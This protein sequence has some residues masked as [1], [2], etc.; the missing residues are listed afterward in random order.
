MNKATVLGCMSAPYGIQEVQV[1]CSIRNGFPGFDI[2]GLPGASVKESRE[3]V[4][5]AMRSSGVGFPQ[6]R[7]LLNLS[8][9]SIQKEGTSL[10]LPIA[11]SI[12]LC[13]ATQSCDGS[14]TGDIRIMAVGELSL[15]GTLIPT[16]ECSGATAKAASTMCQLCLVPE[17][18]IPSPI[19]GVV[20]VRT[21]GQ[22]IEI[23]MG[24]LVDDPSSAMGHEGGTGPVFEDVMGL[25]NQKYAVAMAAA[26]LHNMLLFGP[27]GV[28]KTLMSSKVPL[29]LEVCSV[30]PRPIS[31]NLPHESTT[32]SVLNMLK[33]FSENQPN[34]FG[35]GALVLDELNKYAPKTLD[36]VRDIVDGRVLRGVGDFVVVANMNPCPCG[37]LG[38]RQA[39]CSCTSRRIESYWAKLGRPL[40]ERFDLRLPIEESLDC[41]AFAPTGDEKPDSFYIDRM[42]GSRSR[43]AY[44]YKYIE[45]VSFNGQIGRSAKALSLFGCELDLFARI[46]GPQCS[47]TRS[48]ISTIALARSIAD[49]D[50][51]SNV[52]EEDI[53]AAVQFRRYGLGDYYWKSI[54]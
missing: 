49:F 43:Q 20:R 1:D 40:V 18:S 45:D 54:V 53:L 2:T 37:G 16:K 9:S 23:C 51:R 33:A 41:T 48:R 10:D 27:P 12:A 26:G 8:P 39:L 24:A 50:D 21:L 22:A 38:S 13:K 31:L 32:A 34:G 44:R 14:F 11:L 5:C 42:R 15:D 3:R 4:R 30:E 17:G 46:Y 52:S 47:N 36:L 29:L 28:G 19:P 25:G 7:V 35:G 6:S